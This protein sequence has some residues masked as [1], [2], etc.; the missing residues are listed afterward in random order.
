MLAMTGELRARNVLPVG[1]DKRE[2]ARGAARRFARYPADTEQA[3][4][5]RSSERAA[6]RIQFV[7]VDNVRKVFREALGEKA[8]AVVSAS[9]RPSECRRPRAAEEII[10]RTKMPNSHEDGKRT[11]RVL[12]WL[13]LL[14]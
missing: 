8:K 2:G 6:Q 3:G 5:G 9:P 7:F 12:L 4:S 14:S 1:E 13:V 11:K 10:R